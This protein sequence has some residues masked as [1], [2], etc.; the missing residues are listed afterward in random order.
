M[1]LRTKVSHVNGT[2]DRMP[3]WSAQIWIRTMQSANMLAWEDAKLL[4]V[5]QLPAWYNWKLSSLLLEHRGCWHLPDFHFTGPTH[6]QYGARN[7]RWLFFCYLCFLNTKL[8][9]VLK[10]CIFSSR[11]KE[12]KVYLYMLKPFIPHYI[13]PIPEHLCVCS[14]D[15]NFKRPKESNLILSTEF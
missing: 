7:S 8:N 11:Y 12:K 13:S 10:P 4:L 2:Q 15:L 6:R 5:T 9:I 3:P 1:T 14:Y